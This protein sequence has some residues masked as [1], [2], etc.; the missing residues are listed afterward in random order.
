MLYICCDIVLL[1]IGSFDT[2]LPRKNKNRV[3]NEQYERKKSGEFTVYTHDL[4]D[5]RVSFIRSRER[6]LPYVRIAL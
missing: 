5:P 6:L 2:V 4:H 1:L 3:D